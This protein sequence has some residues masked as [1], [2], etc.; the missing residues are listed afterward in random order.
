MSVFIKL[1]RECLCS[2][3][4]CVHIVKTNF[5][6]RPIIATKRFSVYFNLFTICILAFDSNT[7][8]GVVDKETTIQTKLCI[9]FQFNEDHRSVQWHFKRFVE[10]RT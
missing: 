2:D 5:R 10:N 6:I 7:I 4:H 1:T 8:N 9:A 3:N